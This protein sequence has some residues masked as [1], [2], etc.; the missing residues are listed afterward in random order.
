MK[1]SVYSLVLM[2]DVVEKIDELAYSRGTSRSNLIN[3]ILAEKVS[4]ITPQKRNNE[5]FFYIRQEIT[6]SSFVIADT[7]SSVFAA[8]RALRYKYNPSVKYSVE[9]YP[10]ID[11]DGFLGRIFI[12]IRTK[13]PTLI[14][15]L[16]S[17]YG[18][19][20]YLEQKYGFSN[21]GDTEYDEQGNFTKFIKY[22][23]N[24]EIKD[25]SK[26]ITENISEI[27]TLMQYYI[28]NYD[29]EETEK[30]IEEYFK[31]KEK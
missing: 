11:E 19:Y 31:N 28:K 17:F 4:C 23:E 9:I 1:K 29:N 15:L 5:V 18:L 12:S 25:L 8:K 30:R 20:I 2:D 24:E 22:R 26:R 3:Q 6:N 27:D 10:E 16:I 7:S 14:S 13:N 21:E